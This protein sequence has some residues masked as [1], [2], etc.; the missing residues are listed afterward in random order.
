V[1]GVDW[2]RKLRQLPKWKDIY[3]V[4]VIPT[5]QEP[6]KVLADTIQ[7][8]VDNDYPSEKIIVVLA[9][10]ERAGQEAQE[11]AKALERQFGK[12][13][14]RFLVTTHPDGI[15]G[16]IAGKGSNETYAVKQI[17]E[18]VIDPL[19]IPY[20]KIIL[21]SLDADT[22]PLPKY[23]SC[24]TYHYLTVDNPTRTS[25]QP[26]PLYVN[27]I[28]DSSIIARLFAFSSTFWHMMNQYRPEKLITFS[29]HAMSF[30]ALVDVGF[31]DTNVVSDDSR[32]FWQ[33]FLAFHGE[34]KVH[35][36][37]YPVSMDVNTAPSFIGTVKN[38]YRQQRRW[39]YGVENIPYMLFAFSRD[40]E[41]KFSKKLLF[42]AELI[43]G[44]WSWAT[45]PIL[46]FMLGWLPLLL[47]GEAFSQSLLSYN[48]PR[49]VSW[50]L[51]ISML[52]LVGSVYLSLA[53]LPP[54]P[55][56]YG[57]WKVFVFI[58]QWLL[59]PFTMLFLALPALD[60]QTRLMFKRYLG[61]WV[62]PKY[63]E[64]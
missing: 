58:I 9:M 36:L 59:L 6:K 47:G 45:A 14:F 55:P 35:P 11:I 18:Q 56:Q 20:E 8:I 26:I 57:K 7:A 29:S 16:E 37:Y 64:D 63:R 22:V 4:V 13:F 28:W 19:Q 27:N 24:L 41:I 46:I 44:H 5:Y 12:T 10:E 50:M 60:A 54:R 39:A 52:G 23:F 2:K 38:I 21:S 34:Y 62:T 15:E 43:E 48:L 31:K 25:F 33:C 3:H 51:T 1:E 61:F 49:L 53:L 30:K 17:K 42:G 32:I 40:K